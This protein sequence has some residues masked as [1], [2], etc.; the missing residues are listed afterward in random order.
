MKCN[1]EAK[2]SVCRLFMRWLFSLLCHREF[3]GLNELLVTPFA[4]KAEPAG[5]V[6]A[7]SMGARKLARLLLFNLKTL[8]LS[9]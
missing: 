6:N 7:K 1:K 2:Y 9:E 8:A 3:R 4:H 5:G